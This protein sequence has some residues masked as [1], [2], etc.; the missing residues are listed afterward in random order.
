[1]IR[2]LAKKRIREDPVAFALG[3]DDR[4][5][6]SLS[7]IHL[8]GIA[9]GAIVINV[10]TYAFLK[11]EGVAEAEIFQRIEAHRS[12]LGLGELPA[13]LTLEKYI[14]YRMDLEFKVGAPISK[15]FVTEAVQIAREHFG[16]Q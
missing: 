4:V 7:E 5:V 10:E 16:C 9:E 14:Q 2:K 6:D 13:P 15:E 12:S 3:F 1:L 11:Q 8:M